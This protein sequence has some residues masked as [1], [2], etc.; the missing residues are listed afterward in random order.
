MLR[1]DGHL[2]WSLVTLVLLTVG[3]CQSV[4]IDEEAVVAEIRALYKSAKHIES[5][6]T[7][8]RL[9]LMRDDTDDSTV[10]WVAY[11][12]NAAPLTTATVFLAN[13]VV[14]SALFSEVSQSGDWSLY[15]D[16]YYR[17]DS[18]LA[19]AY[20]ELRT[21]YG[22]VRTETRLYYAR[23]GI[24]VRQID[25][26]F[27]LYSGEPVDREYMR[28]EPVICHSTAVLSSFLG[29]AELSEKKSARP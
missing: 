11:D 3:S 14:S 27:D 16:M 12:D 4:E 1:L 21:F 28:V 15:T 24:V 19:F 22:E 6:S 8:S 18:T 29:V 10:S 5:D 26:V 23:N 7:T 13:G 25:R 2:I 9:R 20:I 17:E